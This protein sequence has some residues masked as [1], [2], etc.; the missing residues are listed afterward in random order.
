MEIRHNVLMSVLL[1]A[2]DPEAAPI[3]LITFKS[4][5]SPEVMMFHEHAERILNLLH[6]NPA[7]GVI[8]ADEA[9]HALSILE[10]EVENTK[11]H[12]KEDVEHDVHTPEQEEGESL[13]HARQQ[14]VGFAARAYPLLAMLRSATQERQ[15]IIWGV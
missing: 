6:K 13:E 7:R 14:R 11:L 8:T 3:M 1:A 15:Y 9:A 5:F 4:K 2:I 10:H 12:P